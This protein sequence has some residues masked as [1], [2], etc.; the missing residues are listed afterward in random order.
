MRFGVANIPHGCRYVTYA[1]ADTADVPVVVEGCVKQFCV[2][3]GHLTGLKRHACRGRGIDFGGYP[4]TS[5]NKITGIGVIIMLDKIVSVTARNYLHAAGLV[6]GNGQGDP[7]RHL[8]GRI[9]E[10]IGAVLMP[11]DKEFERGGFTQ[12]VAW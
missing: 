2:M 3:Y 5:G 12:S 4:L 8:H 9:K 6:I 1:K 7:G 10:E 11:P